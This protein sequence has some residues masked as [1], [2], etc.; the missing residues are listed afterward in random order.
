MKTLI[1]VL[2]VLASVAFTEKN[3]ETQTIKAVFDGYTDGSYS[4]TENDDISYEFQDIEEEAIEKYDLATDKK[5]EGKTFN[6]TYRTDLS[7]DEDG[8][9][10]LVYIIVGLELVE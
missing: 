9:E 5:Y 4:F 1:I 2:F 7:E 6:V 3:Q 8:E 10:Y